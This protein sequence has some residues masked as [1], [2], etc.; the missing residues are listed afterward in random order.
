MAAALLRPQALLGPVARPC[1]QRAAFRPAFAPVARPVLQ[2][3][4]LQVVA[5]EPGKDAKKKKLPSPEKR[6]LTSEERRKYNKGHKS[7]VATRIKKVLLLA[8]QLVAS[9][10]KTEE[11]A[12]PLEALI[13]KA[14]QEIDK[15]VVKGIL[16]PN[17]GGR[18]KA[19][20]ARW[21]RAVLLVGGL[22]TP[23]EDHPDY[24]K[25]QKLVAKQAAAAPAASR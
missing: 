4:A 7:A 10:I 23:A 21:K 6:A 15:A 20:L 13:S 11:E 22:F 14:Y 16:H 12:K 18:K 25:Y 8:E 9:P 19:R 3:G 17:T 2:R 5:A 1:A 24:P